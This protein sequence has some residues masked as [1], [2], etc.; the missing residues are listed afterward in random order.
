VDQ[1][2]EAAGRIDDQIP[3]IRHFR[4]FDQALSRQVGAARDDG[5]R[6][7]IFVVD[8]SYRVMARFDAREAGAIE[9][10]LAYVAGLPPVDDHA[11]TDLHA[12]VLVV[13]R[14]FDPAFCRELIGY[15]EQQGGAD[16]GFMREVDGL[17]VG[18]LNH[19]FKRRSDVHVED[20]GMR[21]RIQALVGRRLVPEIER[22]FQFQATRIERY[23]I[24]CYDGASGGFFR[25]HKD[26]TTLGTAH[27]KF[28]VT[29]NL[30]A[31]EHE[32][33][34]LRFPEFGTRRYK[35]P[36]GGAVVFS[37]SLLHEALP[38]TNGRRYAV[39]PF[40]YDEDGARIRRQNERFLVPGPGAAGEPGAGEIPG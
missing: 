29:I 18:A 7:V 9:R 20:P 6:P 22:A 28:A 4:D 17:T 38:V 16:S 30:N 14:L 32:G 23:I 36:T 10:M 15:F 3:G 12:P 27:R 21:G 19:G 13:P 33:G 5:Y 25:A 39:L 34:E 11:G 37:C 2:D 40:L 35:A 1:A 26:N 31:E 8:P 24:A